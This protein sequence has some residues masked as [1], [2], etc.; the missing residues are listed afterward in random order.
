MT[1]RAWST[2]GGGSALVAPTDLTLGKAL[3][4]ALVPDCSLL[5]NAIDAA[6]APA[7]NLSTTGPLAQ[8][9][10]S[11]TADLRRIAED[12][13]NIYRQ[14][15][16][17]TRRALEHGRY[18]RKT[19][20]RN[21]KGW[22]GTEAVCPDHPARVIYKRLLAESP[23]V[24]PAEAQLHMQLLER[25]LER[26]GDADDKAL[27]IDSPLTLAT[28][29]VSTE[30]AETFTAETTNRDDHKPGAPHLLVAVTASRNAPAD[31]H[32]YAH[33]HKRLKTAGPTDTT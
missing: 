33:T 8:F 4:S 7:R 29:A 21:R 18:R 9:A 12:V 19:R 25:A 26:C 5:R 16:R 17:A 1:T 23:E 22:P 30:G 6:F 3:T 14:M 10:E 28:V 27:H 24:S 20:D 2:V 32:A 11:L 13:K 31:G 15:P